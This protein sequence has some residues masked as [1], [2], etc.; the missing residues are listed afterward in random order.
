MSRKI[1]NSLVEFAVLTVRAACLFALLILLASAVY[2]LCTAISG[3]LG[4][5]G[6]NSVAAPGVV[7]V[8]AVFGVVILTE[9]D[10]DGN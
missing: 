1:L 4:L 10:L 3:L 6:L 8:F 7:L 2:G 5:F 9:G